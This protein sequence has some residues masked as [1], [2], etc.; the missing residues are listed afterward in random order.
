VSGE[1]GS[2]QSRQLRTAQESGTGSGPRNASGSVPPRPW[3]PTERNRLLIWVGI[4][5]ILPAPFAYLM[6][7][8]L[9]QTGAIL[10]VQ[11]E[12][13]LQGVLAF[14]AVLG[15]LNRFADGKASPW[16]ITAFPRAKY[17]E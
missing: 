14:F 5:F 16:T 2:D 17:L 7:L 12:L 6:Q 10:S 1:T 11:S 4:A 15:D 9:K 3:T 8:P 13:P